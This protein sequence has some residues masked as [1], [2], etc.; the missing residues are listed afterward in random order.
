MGHVRHVGV[1]SRAFTIVELLVVLLLAGVLVVTVLPRLYS[2][3]AGDSKQIDATFYQMRA[4]ISVFHAQWVA[5]GRPQAG[6]AVPSGGRLRANAA[7]Y[8]YGQREGG[9]P[10]IE[11]VRDCTDVLQNLVSTSVDMWHPES[12]IRLETR[13]TDGVCRY[14]LVAG[15]GE[16]TTA[17]SSV[18]YYQPD[19]GQLRLGE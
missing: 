3:H 19:A 10:D 4:A 5:A 9:V 13:F 16:S 2:T 1:T 14:Q 8:P 11:S 15:S 12:P 17:E 7:G 6:T 18:I